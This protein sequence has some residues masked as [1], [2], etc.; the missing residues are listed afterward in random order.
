[1]ASG[2]S[3]GPA[4]A[5]LLQESVS[6]VLS[7]QVLQDVGQELARAPDEVAMPL[8]VQTIERL[9]PRLVVFEE[10][11]TDLRKKLAALYEKNGEWVEAAKVL[12]GIPLESSNRCNPPLIKS[13]WRRPVLMRTRG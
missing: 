9:Q 5:T 6:L 4:R 11:V 2:F 3:R 10:P 13:T 7:R 8:L 12:I 1:M